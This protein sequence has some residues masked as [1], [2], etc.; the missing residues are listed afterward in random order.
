[1]PRNKVRI[2][3]GLMIE[4]AKHNPH[5]LGWN[6]CCSISARASTNVTFSKALRLRIASQKGVMFASSLRCQ[7]R[8]WTFVLWLRDP[9]NRIHGDWQESSIADYRTLLPLTSH[10]FQQIA[11]A[12]LWHF[13]LAHVVRQYRYVEF[14]KHIRGFQFPWLLHLPD[15]SHAGW[16]AVKEKQCQ[17]GIFTLRNTHYRFGASNLEQSMTISGDT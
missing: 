3:T 12:T 9:M 8:Q 5:L 2:Q 13:L 1:M 14:Q 17:P 11:L 16:S 7:S 10:G 15:G 6:C 4:S